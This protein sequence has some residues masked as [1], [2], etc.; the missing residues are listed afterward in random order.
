VEKRTSVSDL[1]TGPKE[2]KAETFSLER[3]AMIYAFG[4][5]KLLS[6]R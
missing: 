3:D 6:A 5:H 4:K 1:P 2:L